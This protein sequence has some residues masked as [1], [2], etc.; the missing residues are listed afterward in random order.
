VAQPSASDVLRPLRRTRQYREFTSDP[1]SREALD[2]LADV[3]R[4]SGSGRNSQQWRFILI[5]EAATIMK[6]AAVGMPQTRSLNTAT[7]VIAIV[8]PVA[9]GREIDNAFDDGR[10]AERI[11]IAAGML[12]LG[13]G[14]AWVRDDVRKDVGGLL[15]LPPDRYVRTLMAL[16]HPTEAARAPKSEHG[17]ARLP[18][19]ETV[20]EE[21]W[22]DH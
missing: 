15:D 14:I 5:T 1:V 20:V 16:G 2:A 19:E 21:R 17:K 4:W 22:P 12:G 7:A 13:G 18:R 9:Q 10:V 11:L 6:L 3:A 8:L